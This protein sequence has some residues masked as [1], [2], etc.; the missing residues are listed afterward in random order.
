MEQAIVAAY[1]QS[2]PSATDAPMIHEYPLEG[3]PPMMTHVRRTIAGETVIAGKGALEHV[4]EV[5]QLEPAVADEIRQVAKRLSMQGYRVLGVAKG[6]TP[7]SGF[8]ATQD[9]FNWAFLGLVALENPPKANARAVIQAFTDAGIR[10]KIITGDNLETAQAIARQVGLPDAE[11]FQ[12]GQQIMAMDAATLEGQVKQTAVFARMF[13]EAKLRVVEALKRNGE[14]VA[15]TGDGVN[16]APALKAAHI[17]VAMGQRGTE[18]AKQA[19][20]LVLVNDD[21]GNMV[22]AIA[23]G[24]RIYQNLKKAVAYIVS[25]HIPIILTVAIPLIFDWRIANLFAPIHVIF[26][27]LVMGPTCSIAFENEPAEANQIDR[28]SVV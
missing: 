16:D 10:V 21:L 5:C 24:R 27:E 6:A 18:V 22:N 17:G 4:L 1:T 19:A 28:K 15:M 3:T 9:E 26:L 23:Q 7:T 13:P 25:I 14:V 8:P 20:S 11:R 2:T 12:T